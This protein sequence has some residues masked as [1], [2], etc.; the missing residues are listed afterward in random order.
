MRK[1]LITRLILAMLVL[2]VG[3]IGIALR[4]AVL[5]DFR[6]DKNHE[7]PS[8]DPVYNP[9]PVS[10]TLSYQLSGLMV[11]TESMK[12]RVTVDLVEDCTLLLRFVTEESYFAEDKTGG[13]DYIDGCSSALELVAPEKTEYGL[14]EASTVDAE[15]DIIGVLPERFVA[16]A[17]LVD[18]SG[19][20]L[21]SPVYSI[22]NTERYER[23]E[24]L[25]P[26]DFPET[27]QIVVF[28]DS[29]TDTVMLADTERE[30]SS[31]TNFGVLAD[32]VKIIGCESF[33][34]HYDEYNWCYYFEILSPSEK[35]SSGDVIYLS[36]G[37]SSQ[38]I[39][40]F[41]PETEG[42][43]VTVYATSNGHTYMSKYYKF[44]KVDACFTEEGEVTAEHPTE[45]AA[46][47]R[48][49]EQ[50]KE[51]IDGFKK[52]NN[53][54]IN[55]TFGDAQGSSQD[56]KVKVEVK[57][58]IKDGKIAVKGYYIYAPEL[59]GEDYFECEVHSE[60]DFVM[61]AEITASVGTDDNYADIKMGKIKRIGWVTLPTPVPGLMLKAEFGASLAGKIGGKIEIDDLPLY[62]KYGFRYSTTEGYT[63]LGKSAGINGDK[64][65]DFFNC[66]AE[67]EIYFGP[68][69][70]IGAELLWG[71][72]D[73]Q[74]DM[75]LT[76]KLTASTDSVHNYTPNEPGVVHNC[77]LCVNAD[78]ALHVGTTLKLGCRIFKLVEY[79]PVN[80]KVL[81]TNLKIG[82]FYVSIP[83]LGDSVVFGT[84]D[85]QNYS[86]VV[87][88]DP[89]CTAEEFF[90]CNY[91]DSHESYYWLQEE[92]ASNHFRLDV[93]SEVD[94]VTGR[95]I[96]YYT[97]GWTADD[98][99]H[100]HFFNYAAVSITNNDTGET[101][102][103]D[104]LRM[105][106][107]GYNRPILDKLTPKIPLSAKNIHVK[108]DCVCTVYECEM[109]KWHRYEEDS[110][111]TYDSYHPQRVVEHSV[112]YNLTHNFT[113]DDEPGTP[114]YDYERQEAGT[115]PFG[116]VEKYMM[117][118]FSKAFAWNLINKD[119]L[120]Y[121]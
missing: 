31:A 20:L 95:P 99:Y 32:G 49:G 19:E 86:A 61:K 26:A 108:I 66:S 117:E 21:G 93:V 73:F 67:A 113:M 12:A 119:D 97:E 68:R 10:K 87:E 54:P 78:F 13:L 57:G 80:Y 121:K 14:V 53:F 51:I 107:D 43:T 58:N 74:A 3:L 81:D 70:N 76:L 6:G 59:F 16:E 63:A 37:K 79:Y 18:G 45:I 71:V 1:K 7:D 104:V 102:F 111:D 89:R 90:I 120:G 11:D 83:K 9:T 84:G 17:V 5:P 100:Y 24:A 56:S 98:G 77:E 52:I 92:S 8:D 28:G 22:K 82:E 2:A 64:D 39:S 85:C 46:A 65:K 33:T 60:I 62:G 36:D 91:L 4:E 48:S 101:I 42:D 72:V 34:T 40:V 27:E 25:T 29:S 50:D 41:Y 47:K 118:F 23:F 15:L 116:T 55:L 115:G 88:L 44:L 94:S 109:Q 96:S 38:L 103:E 30:D 112:E 110:L 75:D 114:G 106:R 35:I 105:E 69:I